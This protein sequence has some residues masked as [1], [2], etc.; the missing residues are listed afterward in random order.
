MR[1]SIE[2]WRLRAALVALVAALSLAGS[3]ASA[4]ETCVSCHATQQDLRLRDPVERLRG[5]VHDLALGCSGCHGGRGNEPTV[6]AHDVSAGFVARPDPATVADRCGTCHA[7][8]RFIRRHRDDLPTDQLALFHADSHGRALARGN[9]AAPS[10]LGCHGS[11]DVRAANDPASRVAR[12]RQ[13]E[14]CGGCHSDPARMAGTRLPTN[15]AAL[16][17]GSVHGRAVLAQGSLSAPTCAG[18]HGAHG[19]YREAGGPE[20]RC[21]H[22]HEAEAEAFDRSPHASVYRRLG[23]SG[24]V[25]CHGSHDVREANGALGTAGSMGVCRRCHGE[26]RESDGVARRIAAEAERARR[27]LGQ[28][29]AAVRAMEAAGLRVP[30]VKAL[31]D[32]AAQADVRLRVAMHA[33]DEGVAREAASA[34]SRSAQRARELA[35]RTRE[36]D[37]NGRRAWL[38]ALP[39]LAIL[40][41][42]LLLK[43]RQIDRRGG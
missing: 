35:R 3:S 4:Q 22:C 6:Q 11:H 10:C 2:L 30:A 36:R 8:A 28:A 15:Q 19:E 32:E 31:V 14:T 20:G 21:R 34:V 5:S 41:A 12:R 25:A 43:I 7:D 16:W 39:P 33:L 18:C 9:L 17:A 1:F 13:H 26:G 40:A 38:V 24:C 37:A 42:L 23:F 29:R 27:D